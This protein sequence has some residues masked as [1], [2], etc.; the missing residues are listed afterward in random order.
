MMWGRMA[1]WCWVVGCV[2]LGGST[3]VWGAAWQIQPGIE[4]KG[5]Y[6]NNILNSPVIRKADYILSARPSLALSYNSEVARIEGILAVLGL[7]YLHNDNLDKINQ[8]YNINANY[9]ATPRLG[10]NLATAFISDSTTNQELQASGVTIG[11]SLRTSFAAAPGLNF[12]LTERWSTSLQYN[13]NVVNYQETIY[14]NY[15]THSL[16][17]GFDY[18]LN[19]R[20]SLLSRLTAY[21]SKY[22]NNN[23]ITSLGPQIGFRH[24]YLEK[25]DFMVLGGVNFS[26]IKSDTRVLAVNNFTGF[27]EVRQ[28]PQI[29]RSQS[30]FFTIE[31]GYRWQTG[32]LRL[33]YNRSQSANAY[34]NQSQYNSFNF[35][36]SQKLSE[37]LTFSLNPYLNTSSISNPGSDYN[38]TYMGIRPGLSYRF[39]EKILLGTNYGFAYRSV[40]GT[41]RYR[42]P[43][44][45]VFLTLSYS[46]PFHLD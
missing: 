2:L 15:E 41:T 24:I 39:T 19:E 31:G 45:E 8:Y 1:A 17:H 21:F 44:N 38:S 26:R 28:R 32:S 36:T 22:S 10:L 23:T 13:F 25:W 46:S 6:S 5:Q 30:P 7:H 4:T 20:T 11:R 34:G 18:A 37:R 29:A 9:K 14:N 33:S 3:L 40:S 43:I 35:Y 42:Y 27:L 16:V 12:L